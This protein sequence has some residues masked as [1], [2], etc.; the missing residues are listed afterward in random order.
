MTIYPEF[1]A[2]LFD[3]Y[4]PLP[5]GVLRTKIEALA[6]RLTFPL[7]KL[8]VVEGKSTVLNLFCITL[9]YKNVICSGSKRSA[10]SNA[11]LYGF[12]NNKR[13]VLYDT[14]LEDYSP[15]QREDKDNIEIKEEEEGKEYETKEEGEKETEENIEE[16]KETET[17]EDVHCYICFIYCRYC[18][19]VMY[20]FFRRTMPKKIQRN[21]RNLACQTTK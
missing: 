21:A 3:K 14:L 13:I 1:I 2:P 15:V 18:I 4:T 7:K 10:H 12:W 17:K 20:L 8:Y 5:D 19:F 11:Y 6:A 16:S 9:Q